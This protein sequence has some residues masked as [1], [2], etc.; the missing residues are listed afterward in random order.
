VKRH[1]PLLDIPRK[2]RLLCG[3]ALIGLL[4][5][6]AFGAT[7]VW[8]TSTTANTVQNSS[9]VWDSTSLSWSAAPSS[10]TLAAWADGNLA[11]FGGDNVAG[12]T[13][14]S[15]DFTVTVDGAKSATSVRQIA[16]GLGNYTLTGGTINISTASGLRVDQGVFTI[17]STITANAGLALYL[18]ATAADSVLVLGGNNTGL[19]DPII[20]SSGLGV[21]K[22][23]S[24]TALGSGSGNNLRIQSNATNGTAGTLDINGLTIS[25]G[26][27]LINDIAGTGTARLINSNTNSVAT[28]ANG[29]FLNANSLAFGGD[30]AGLILSGFISGS[31]VLRTTGTSVVTVTRTNNTYSGGTVVDSGTLLIDGNAGTGAVSVGAAGTL[32]GSGTIAGLTTI[33]GALAPGTTFGK[34]TFTAA[35][36]AGTALTLTSTAH[37]VMQISNTTPGTGH[38]QIALTGTGNLLS[39]GGVLTLSIGGLIQEGAYDLFSFTNEV[40]SGV[41]VGSFSS[42]TFAGGIYSGTFTDAG[43][44]GVWTSTASN[45]QVFTFTEST[46][47]LLVA[48]VPEPSVVALLGLG[49]SVGVV[50]IARRRRVS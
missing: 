16:N 20:V 29:I 32:G 8:N 38:D 41:G 1:I 42:I 23:T 28:F 33:N 37:T 30:G 43:N 44:T 24:A 10:G 2:S 4:A 45:G 34:L 3:A 31:G 49:L 39:Y 50:L 17:N 26:R 46:G 48:A 13:L 5:P 36:S 11:W 9:G 15:G 22:L 25:Q 6:T 18:N 27:A 21:V 35:G 47:D 12:H 40:A 7:Q 19:S 14:N